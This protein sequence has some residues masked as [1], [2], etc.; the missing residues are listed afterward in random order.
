M[1]GGYRALPA[2]LGLPFSLDVAPTSAEA[3]LQI[4]RALSQRVPDV[5]VMAG[6]LPPEPPVVAATPSCAAVVLSQP[7]ATWKQASLEAFTNL[8]T[9]LL[10]IA[11]AYEEGRIASLPRHISER[12]A[13][14]KT[15]SA[16]AWRRL[17]FGD[18]E[19]TSAAPA[20]LPPAPA[21]DE[22]KGRQVWR[23]P[24][25]EDDDE[26]EEEEEE[27][28]E[29]EGYDDGEDKGEWEEDQGEDEGEGGV[30]GGG[31]EDDDGNGDYEE[32]GGG[33]INAA[34]G[35]RRIDRPAWPSKVRVL[36]VVVLVALLKKK[37][38]SHL[39]SPPSYL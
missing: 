17:C 37:N 24:G 9:T 20:P 2:P 19:S 25:E 23:A 11:V 30:E 34:D 15:A 26:N 38:L 10:H 7:D 36:V 32:G 31:F 6:G 14:L 27:E 13:P 1:Q 21:D 29:E 35:V 5:M 33:A 3:Y 4:V 12:S 22:F 18:V 16:A 28:E 39:S 8:R